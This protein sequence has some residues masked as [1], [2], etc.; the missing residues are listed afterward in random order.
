MRKWRHA[1]VDNLSKIT[2]LVSK[3]S[4]TRMPE[5]ELL[6]IL[7]LCLCSMINNSLLLKCECLVEIVTYN[8]LYLITIGNIQ[9]SCIEFLKI[10]V[11]ARNHV[12]GLQKLKT[13]R[14]IEIFFKLFSKR[15]K[16]PTASDRKE[17]NNTFY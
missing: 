13:Y 10:W 1:E 4:G 6:T 16:M 12:V 5:S 8:I 15:V 2:L 3:R 7:P 17:V 11:Y 14:D 9:V